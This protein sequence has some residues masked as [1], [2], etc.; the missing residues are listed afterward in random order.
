MHRFTLTRAANLLNNSKPGYA[1]FTD[2]KE[3]KKAVML[4]VNKNNIEEAS[5]LIRE[6]LNVVR[7]LNFHQRQDILDTFLKNKQH[8][9]AV[10]WV[11]ISSQDKSKIDFDTRSLCNLIESSKTFEVAN[12]IHLKIINKLVHP[13]LKQNTMSTFSKLNHINEAMEL[14]DELSPN[15]LINSYNCGIVIRQCT[16]S[17]HIK[18]IFHYMKTS[19]FKIDSFVFN[20]VLRAYLNEPN[21]AI[22]LFQFQMA[23]SA[24]SVD[25]YVLNTM[26]SFCNQEKC[27]VDQIC[28]IAISKKCL[29]LKLCTSAI[30]MLAAGDRYKAAIDMFFSMIDSKMVPDSTVYNVALNACANAR[31]VDAGHQII[32]HMKSSRMALNIELYTSLIKYYA[33][34]TRMDEAIDSFD[35]MIRSGIQPNHITFNVL[36]VACTNAQDVERG[37][38]IFRRIIESKIELNAKLF[39]SLIKMYGELNKV[40]KAIELWHVMLRRNVTPDLVTLNIILNVCANSENFQGDEILDYI[41][42]HKVEADTSLINS[43]I[44]YYGATNRLSNAFKLFHRHTERGWMPNALTYMLLIKACSQSASIKYGEMVMHHMRQSNV[45]INNMLASVI[46]TM[47]GRCNMIDDAVAYFEQFKTDP[48]CDVHVW[49]AIMQCFAVSG[50][51]EGTKSYFDRMIHHGIKPNAGSIVILLNVFSHNC[52]VQGAL[53]I[54]NSLPSYNI[55]PDVMIHCCMIDVLGRSGEMD[56]ALALLSSL[57]PNNIDYLN[58]LMGACRIHNNIEIA[59]HCFHQLEKLKA[60]NASN[61]ATLATILASNKKWEERNELMNKMNHNKIKRIPGISTTTIN[62][63]LFEFRVGDQLHPAS[64]QIKTEL[65]RLRHVIKTKYGYNPDLSCATRKFDTQEQ[66]ENHLWEH[67]EKLALA[68][69]L[70][71]SKPNDRIRITNNLRMCKDCHQ[72]VKNISMEVDRTI[73][74][75]DANRWHVFYNGKCSCKDVY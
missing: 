4:S 66:I 62:N 39:S 64:D 19:N 60:L 54:Y 36:L 13:N 47:Y 6:N 30:K 73:E 45:Q 55:K 65:N 10:Q 48:S 8:R 37:N 14:F 35:R 69:N 61:Y 33:S 44:K 75:R 63:Q 70:V 27:L 46:I 40:Q 32:E 50:N 74:I 2:P 29:D 16:D 3:F 58:V 51:S 17:D 24:D 22:A 43:I 41:S 1:K 12:E 15:N 20:K 23:T 49:G 21:E 11:L 67:S 52:N 72:A 38:M 9:H 5:T 28:E 71:L 68:A 25:A 42:K 57:D 7:E 56:R 31:D 26:L 34:T 59:Q 53:E 18:K